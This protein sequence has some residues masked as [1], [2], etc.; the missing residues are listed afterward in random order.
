MEALDTAKEVG[1]LAAAK[2][3]ECILRGYDSALDVRSKGDPADRVT[4]FDI[5][6]QDAIV[7]I[8]TSHFPDHGFLGE[9]DLTKEGSGEGAR[10]KWVI[11]PIDGT[12]N[13][14]QRL[15][16]VGVSIA[17]EIDGVSSLGVLHF[18]VLRE[19]YVA[20]R[21]KGAFLNDKRIFVEDRTSLSASV[22]G[23]IFSDRKH[24]G[25][26]VTY[27][28]VLAF[29]KYGSAV[30]SLAYVASGRIHAAALQCYRWDI[31]AAEVIIAEAGGA[32]TW[33]YDD[34]DDPRSSLACFA[35]AP[36][37]HDEFIEVARREF[38]VE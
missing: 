6:A 16:H 32:M 27:P 23:E 37:I 31:A 13:F 30:T 20:V 22:I 26:Q 25:K 35:S 4:Q 18:P 28:P 3:G 9:E 17:L 24:R 12:S 10:Y 2:A 7:S 36:G 19:T 38:D 33:E 5:E 8:I 15:P 21:G 11:D 1:L 34:P 14:I 29:R